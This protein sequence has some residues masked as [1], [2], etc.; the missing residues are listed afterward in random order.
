MGVRRYFRWRSAPGVT[1]PAPATP[2]LDVTDNA[3]GTGGVATIT[4]ADGGTTNTL[5][6]GSLTS[7]GALT[8]V[9]SRSGNG[10]ITIGATLGNFVWIV[11]S[12]LGGPD[13]IAYDVQAITGAPDSVYAK[14]LADVATL[15]GGVAAGWTIVVRKDLTLLPVELDNLPVIIIKPV[16]KFS[17]QEAF[18]GQMERDYRVGLAFC[19]AGNLKLDTQL[20]PILNVISAVPKALNVTSLPTATT[21]WDSKVDYSPTFDEAGIPANVDRT[22]IEVTYKSQE[23]RTA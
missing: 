15:T 17:E 14:I 13:S 7:P 23:L 1:P 5:Y 22:V 12:T 8:S 21:V 9:G 3:D 18:E 16:E 4:N 6:R 19:Y 2:T 10:T 20:A 11:T